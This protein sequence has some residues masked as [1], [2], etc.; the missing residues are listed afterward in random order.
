MKLKITR[1]NISHRIIIMV[2]SLMIPVFILV[3]M[4]VHEKNIAITFGQKEIYGN[5]AL[6]ILRQIYER[7]ITQTSTGSE[8]GSNQKLTKELDLYLKE[9][10]SSGKYDMNVMEEFNGLKLALEN[11]GSDIN[12]KLDF[13]EK[14][15]S[16][17]GDRSN[18]ILDPDLDS[19]YLMDIVVLKIPEAVRRLVSLQHLNIKASAG[20]GEKYLSDYIALS[21]LLKSSAEGFRNSARV[22]GENDSSGTGLISEMVIKTADNAADLVV[23]FTSRSEG[24]YL[25]AGNKKNGVP[26][27]SETMGG[28]YSLFDASSETLEYFLEKRISQFRVKMYISLTFVFISV[29]IC[30]YIALRIIKHIRRSLSG[31]NAL[32]KFM[33]EGDLTEKKIDIAEDE[34]GDLVRNLVHFNSRVSELIR[35]TKNMSGDVGASSEKLIL[36][37]DIFSRNAQEQAASTEE[38]SA[39]LEEF[40]ANMENISERTTELNESF[41]LM[42][43]KM[44]GLAEFVNTMTGSIDRTF[45]LTEKITLTGTNQKSRV[46]DMTV[47]MKKISDTSREMNSIL[48]I[49]TDISEQINLLSLNA[50]IEAARAGESG[51]GFAVVADEISK[52][53]DLTSSSIKDIARLIGASEKETGEGLND[54]NIAID[55]MGEILKGISDIREMLEGIHTYM[56]KQIEINDSINIAADSIMR[57]FDLAKNSLLEQQDATHSVTDAVSDIN[58]STQETARNA[59]ELH[60]MAGSLNLLVRQLMN[61]VDYFKC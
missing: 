19:Y 55:T 37:A 33:A 1:I 38:I 56:Q 14:L 15:W 13:S 8:S 44:T 27:I 45:M 57:K 21:G 58:R 22:A 59:S 2:T 53:A 30:M 42:N 61:R 12:S 49:I 24:L 18:L 9:K 16:R 3:A 41:M 29:I 52:L 17:I 28:V 35:E 39:T 46:D 11:A 51:R 25:P 23:R 40:L 5:N 4:L 47:R 26:D 32:I 43:R 34:I 20:N 48:E 60:E 6:E 7:D 36:D 54:V 31:G 50:S 10:C